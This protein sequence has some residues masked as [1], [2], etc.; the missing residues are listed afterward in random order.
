MRRGELTEYQWQRLKPLLPAQKPK[1]GRP[2][3]PH[4]QILNG[5]LWILRTGAPW[6]DLPPHYGAWQTV[7]CRFYRWQK[8]G[9]WERL[10]RALQQQ[11]D[12]A[13]LLDWNLHLVDSTLVRAHQHAAGARGRCPK[14][15]S[16]GQKP[17]RLDH[18]DASAL[19]RQRSVSDRLIDPRRAA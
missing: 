13:G 6:R 19:R 5:I 4:R 12:A 3:L 16:V 14:S 1:L 18:Q 2:A 17:R 9:I 10:V 11:A 15:R 8:A 7:A